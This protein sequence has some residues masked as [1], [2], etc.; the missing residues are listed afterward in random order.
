MCDRAV[1]VGPPGGELEQAAHIMCRVSGGIH[2]P[3]TEAELLGP[4]KILGCDTAEQTLEIYKQVL[5]HLR[6]PC[7]SL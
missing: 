2:S 7:V 5:R 3:R 1:A 6:A 4:A